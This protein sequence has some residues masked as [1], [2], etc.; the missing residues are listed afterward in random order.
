MARFYGRVGYGEQTEVS[1]GVFVDAIVE[2]V[3]FGTEV[4]TSRALREGER[5]NQDLTVGNSISI[6]GNEYAWSHIQSIRYVEWAGQLWTVADVE[7]ER[8]RL[9]LRLGEVYNGPTPTP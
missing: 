5:L 4:R 3:Y 1:P 8:P 7:V 6:V 2:R 9:V